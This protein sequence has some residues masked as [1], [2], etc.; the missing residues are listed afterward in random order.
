MEKEMTF[1]EF[2]RR[3]DLGM[4]KLGV[5]PAPKYNAYTGED[6]WR[7]VRDYEIMERFRRRGSF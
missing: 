7:E 3:V 5:P 4:K 6:K 1:E 2:R